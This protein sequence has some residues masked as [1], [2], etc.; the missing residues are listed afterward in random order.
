MSCPLFSLSP[1]KFHSLLLSL[2][3]KIYKSLI[4]VKST[5]IEHKEGPSDIFA[6]KILETGH[7][8]LNAHPLLLFILTGDITSQQSQKSGSLLAL[9]PPSSS[10]PTQAGLPWWPASAALPRPLSQRVQ[11]HKR[12]D[13]AS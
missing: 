6:A 13:S 8:Q 9:P 7:T 2:T 1:R 3:C 4:F 5:D 10:P 11:A 12:E